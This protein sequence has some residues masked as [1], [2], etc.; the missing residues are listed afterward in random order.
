MTGIKINL[1]VIVNQFPAEEND[2]SG[3]F[4][5]DYIK[6]VQPYVEVDVLYLNPYRK[7]NINYTNK[8]I[9]VKE[10]S[11]NAAKNSII[12]P[13]LFFLLFIK[14]FILSS[15]LKKYDVLHTH[16]LIVGGIYCR[17]I[18]FFHKTPFYITVHDTK[19]TK[20]RLKRWIAHGNSKK[21]CKILTV[22]KL[23]ADLISNSLS[24]SNGHTIVT[25]NPVDTQIF[26]F[27]DRLG[28]KQSI[29]FAG[30]LIPR[31]GALRLTHAFI[32]IAHQIPDWKLIIIGSGIEQ[33]VIK[34]CIKAALFENRIVL[35]GRLQKRS[36]SEYMQSS[37]IFAFPTLH[38]T[39][40]LV[41]AE[42]M[43]AGLP[44]ITS[45]NTATKEYVH[46]FS[47]L[48]INPADI[49][50]IADAILK[51]I[52]NLEKYDKT[53]IR[54]YVVDN[55]SFE[56]FGKKLYSLYQQAIVK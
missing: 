32:K 7:L 36:I 40:G 31:K 22:S 26:R 43:S 3:I 1:L 13:F 24:I 17:L 50:D 51:M 37:S 41:V 21:A 9:N 56:V 25:Y 4:V 48:L 47:G 12:K 55:F 16:D 15:K 42:A 8:G 2:I 5:L 30:N 18:N 49:N 52:N 35:K 29:L 19:W 54:Q 23:M 45:C 20:N 44:V 38:E 53:K 11:F 34:N 14:V 33:E 46:D 6:S 10:I 28:T 39:F 27:S